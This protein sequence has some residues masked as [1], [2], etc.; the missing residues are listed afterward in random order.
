MRLN[1]NFVK[2]VLHEFKITQ[3]I[4]TVLLVLVMILNTCF[5]VF[6]ASGTIY[7]D[8]SSPGQSLGLVLDPLKSGTSRKVT[9]RCTG[10]PENAVIES[11]TLLPGKGVVNGGKH[12]L[13]GVVTI[14]QVNI[15]AP[16]GTKK[17]LPWSTDITT[18]DFN[19]ARVNGNWKVSITGKNISKP[20]ASSGLVPRS[21]VGSI[22]YQEPILRIKYHLN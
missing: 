6:A 15:E 19:K 17:I 5:V 22:I 10:V 18:T 16:D 1:N 3:K 9:F 11:V 14:E 13:L 12:V 4:L 7:N 2:E 20:I 21:A 8:I